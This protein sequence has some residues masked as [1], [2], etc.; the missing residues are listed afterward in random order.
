LD[1]QAASR[2][3]YPNLAHWLELAEGLWEKHG[4]GG[5]S[6]RQRWDFN[7]AISAHFPF[8]KYRVLYAASGTQPAAVKLIGDES[9]IAEHK[10][11]WGACRSVQ[12]ADF[13]CSILNSEVARSRAEHWQS[14]GQWGKRDFDKAMFNLPI[15][16]FD[17]KNELHRELAAAGMHAEYVAALAEVKPGEYFVTTRNRI[18]RTLAEEGIGG[19]IEKLVEKLLDE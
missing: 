6:L 5:M 11:Y 7:R 14:E 18:R 1:S 4:T 13:L 9:A 2:A 8:S 19:E 12:E 3:G 16:L 17:P 15:P 10:L